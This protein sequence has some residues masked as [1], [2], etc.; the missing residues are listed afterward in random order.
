MSE[1][2]KVL[3]NL[4]IGELRFWVSGVYC[5]NC[6]NKVKRALKSIGS[7][8]DIEIKPDF[9]ELKALVILK[10]RGNITRKEIEEVLSEA[11][12]ETPYHEYRPIWES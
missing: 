11:S 3:K 2:D 5:N 10:Y 12:D 1:I 7:V 4:N 6:V 9:K 8:E